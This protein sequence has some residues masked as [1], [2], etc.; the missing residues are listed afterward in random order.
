MHVLRRFH[1]KMRPGINFNMGVPT[2]NIV[3]KKDGYLQQGLSLAELGGSRGTVTLEH[4]AGHEVPRDSLST[5]KMTRVVQDAVE[6]VR[7][8]C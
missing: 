6:K 4:G 3:G 5:R 8:Q 2:V 7:F 1:P